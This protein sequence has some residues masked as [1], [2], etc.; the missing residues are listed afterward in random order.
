MERG[1]AVHL[2]TQYYDEGRLDRNTVDPIIAP[3]LEAYI[4]WLGDA[5]PEIHLIEQP[6]YHNA[7][8]YAGTLDRVV[9]IG[10]VWGIL[11]IK[12]GSAPLYTGPQLSGYLGALPSKFSYS[13][14]MMR[15][16]VVLKADGTWK[17]TRFEDQADWD[18]FRAA[19]TLYR[20]K[21]AHR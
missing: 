13:G 4:Q 18:A 11:D 6:I 15:W 3:F 16:A 5:K 1:R 10:G 12:T 7:L 8:E 2:A 14:P 20:W 19:L 9:R 17:M 21:E